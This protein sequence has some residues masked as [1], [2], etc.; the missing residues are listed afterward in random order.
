MTET[1]Q[2]IF[3]RGYEA[4][5]GNRLA[6]ARAIFIAAVRRAAEEGDRPSLAE[7]LCGLGNAEHGIGNLEAA[8]HHYANAV[9]LYRQDGPPERLAEA[10]RQE[11]HIERDL[12]R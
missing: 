8:R 1:F 5:H 4:S 2:Q 9:L 7:A 6:D 11:A 3:A 12:H 10:L